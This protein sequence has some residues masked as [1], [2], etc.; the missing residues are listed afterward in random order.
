VHYLVSSQA[1]ASPAWLHGA[2]TIQK[3]AE[4]I[5]SLQN[6]PVYNCKSL[7]ACDSTAPLGCSFSSR[8]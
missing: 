2:F 5:A 1:G 7:A 6:I 4:G 8:E 3:A